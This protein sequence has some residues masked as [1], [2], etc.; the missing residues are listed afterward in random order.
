M[1]KVLLTTLSGVTALIAVVLISNY[2]LYQFPHI[3]I[4]L[5]L[6]GKNTDNPEYDAAE[7]IASGQINCYSLNGFVP[8]FPGL[9]TERDKNICSLANEINF[10]ATSDFVESERHLIAIRKAAN[11]AA[12]YN[13]YV[14]RHE[15]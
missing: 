8:Y 14:A 6:L 4:E 15:E 11:Y 1:K 13:L 5:Q 10:S 9:E 12:K 7:D 3:S 2:L